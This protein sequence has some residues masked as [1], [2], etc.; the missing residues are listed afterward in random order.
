MDETVF[1]VPRPIRDRFA[2]AWVRTPDG[3]QS[4]DA[5]PVSHPEFWGLGHALT[6]TGP[7]YLR[8]LRML[9]SC[10]TLDGNRVL[11]A[12]MVDALLAAR[13]G[14][15]GP[16]PSLNPAAS[17]TVI[18]FGPS[19]HSLLGVRNEAAIPGRRAAGA[20]GWAGLYNTHWWLDPGRGRAG[21]FLTQCRPFFD[22]RII[23]AFDAFERAVHD[24]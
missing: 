8:F 22:P 13:T 6:G 1:E 15:L 20:Q 3:L 16:M 9:L 12:V 10:G 23:A 24:L 11:S 14:P 19:T 18:R 7:D 2:N 17:A 5:P 4:T 21:L